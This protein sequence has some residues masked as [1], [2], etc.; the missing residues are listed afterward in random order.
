MNHS[1]FSREMK[2]SEVFHANLNLA[3][4]M[5]RLGIEF[6]FGEKTIEQSCNQYGVDCEFFLM[7]CNVYTFPEYLPAEQSLKSLNLDQLLEF[8]LKSH[9]YY[10]Q[11][12]LPHIENHWKKI[13][14]TTD[15][16]MQKIL[17]KFYIEYGMEVCNHFKYEEEVVFPHIRLLLE[18]Q[19]DKD[20]RIAQ[21]ADIHSNIEDKL[22]DLIN[23][24]IKYLPGKLQT[25][26]RISILRDINA[27]SNDLNRHALIEDKIL[28]PYVEYLESQ[29]YE[30]E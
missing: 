1:F 15:E 21:F 2:M 5:P 16:S 26:D 3:M 28:I 18:N 17:E 20:Y 19:R 10:M 8:L 13:I 4:I 9:I 29:C 14:A 27:L 25:A 7:I 30:K 11:E 12:R 23:I 6:G 22:A 24:I